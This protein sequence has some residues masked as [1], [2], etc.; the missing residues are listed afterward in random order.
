M[1]GNSFGQAFRIT[2]AGESHGPGNVVIIDGVPPGIPISVDDLQIDLDRRRPGQSKIVTQR[3]E[4]DVPEILSGVFEGHTTGTSLAILI[5]N[6]DQRSKDYSAIK[7]VYRPG[8]A[9]YSFDAKYGF[10]DY[11]GGGRSSARE[12]TVR[13]AAGVVAKKLIEAAFGGRVTG[14]VVQVGDIRADVPDPAA[15]TLE[16]VERSVDGSP[17]IVRCPDAAAAERMIALI[18]ECRKAGDSIGGAAEIVATNVPPGLGEPVFDKLKADLAKALFS[19]PAVLG[20]EYGIG[21]GCVTM[22]GSRH[23][24]VF[25]AEPAPG[26]GEKPEVSTETNRHGGM[27][28]GISTGMPIVLRAAVKPT[29]SLPIEQ[30]TISK[31]GERTSISTKGRHDPCLLPR[32]V[33]MAEAMIAIVLADH[34]LRWQSQCTNQ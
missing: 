29:S 18:E 19:L 1:P 30:Q 3:D 17:N 15:V 16:Q 34:W 27:L 31:D 10:R 11:R 8:H 9:D 4:P 28:G 13:V 14:Y 33:P 23:N 12:T 20:V 5:R 6:R 7:D 24:D 21:F 2:T 32:F 22:R 25:T 26:G